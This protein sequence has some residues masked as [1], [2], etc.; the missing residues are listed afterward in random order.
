MIKLV[1]NASTLHKSTTI[2]LSIVGIVLGLAEIVSTNMGF[3]QA[4]IAPE[5]YGY[6]MFG[7]SVLIAVGRYVKQ[8]SVSGEIPTAVESQSA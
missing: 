1:E 2:L 7:L 3:L 6:V 4:I 8:F 5:Y